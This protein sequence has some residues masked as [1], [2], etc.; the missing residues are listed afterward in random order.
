M[1]NPVSNSFR[2]HISFSGAETH[3]IGTS[4]AG[5]KVTVFYMDV[6]C[7]SGIHVDCCIGSTIVTKGVFLN[8]PVQLSFGSGITGDTNEGINLTSTGDAEVTIGYKEQNY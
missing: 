7:A 2:K 5:C 3:V 6:F 4:V 1:A 8:S